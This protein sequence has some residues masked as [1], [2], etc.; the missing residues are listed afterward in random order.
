MN[1]P[2]RYACLSF[3]SPPHGPDLLRFHTQILEFDRVYDARARFGAKNTLEQYAPEKLKKGDLVLMESQ[4]S[5]YNSAPKPAGSNKYKGRALKPSEFV[6]WK[7]TFDLVA[8][9]LLEI[10]PN[11]VEAEDPVPSISDSTFSL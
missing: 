2:R 8:V 3:V 5:R 1:A 6:Q 7:A 11:I 4:I 10:G 9:S